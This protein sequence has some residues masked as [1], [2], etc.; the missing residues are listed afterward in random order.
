MLKSHDSAFR[1]G[2]IAILILGFVFTL[3]RFHG[4]TAVLA[5][6]LLRGRQSNMTAGWFH[7]RIDREERMV[8]AVVRE[9]PYGE[10][11][12]G[13]FGLEA[14]RAGSPRVREVDGA[15]DYLFVW[16]YRPEI[17]Y[18]SG[19][20]PASRYLSTQ[21]LTGVPADVH[22]FA[23]YDRSVLDESTSLARTA[24]QDLQETSPYIID[25]L[26]MFNGEL[27]SIVIPS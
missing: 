18:I 26:G 11:A 1:A 25:E 22:Y 27:R 14:M 3:V 10:D 20:L 17:Y 16:G 19:L 12:G 21:P 2:I 24:Y 7:E 4:R 15:T 8:A 13:R 9:L 6:D 5:A 23:D